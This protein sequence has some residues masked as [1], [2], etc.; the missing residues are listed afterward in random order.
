MTANCQ[1]GLPFAWLPLPLSSSENVVNLMFQTFNWNVKLY[2]VCHWWCQVQWQQRWWCP[3]WGTS[4]VASAWT[5]EVSAPQAAWCLF[6]PETPAYPASTS[7]LPPQ[8]PP[9]LSLTNLRI[10]LDHKNTRWNY[11]NTIASQF[12]FIH[13]LYCI[14]KIT[15][16][17]DEASFYSQISL[18]SS[19]H[20]FHRM[21][22]TFLL[23]HCGHCWRDC[24]TDLVCCTFKLS[25]SCSTTSQRCSVRSDLVTR[26]DTEV[27][28]LVSMFITP[29]R[30]TLWHVDRVIYCYYS[31]FTKCA[32]ETFLAPLL[33][34]TTT[35][36]DCSTRQ[37]DVITLKSICQFWSFQFKVGH[38]VHLDAFLLSTVV[39][40]GCL[41]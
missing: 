9:G 34:T 31:R 25:T 5:L 18:S 33:Y 3:F 22:E 2:T 26:G 7:S 8:T 41:I 6:C 13:T 39:Q 40:S 16:L 21:L 11:N 15:L 32:K 29:A 19:L 1:C 10:P 38:V 37:I 35:T 23:W 27:T 12:I 30:G 14:W 28:E 20:G 17:L 24:V 4:P 36:L